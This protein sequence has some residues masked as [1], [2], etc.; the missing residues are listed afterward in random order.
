MPDQFRR[1]TWVKVRNGDVTEGISL[2]RSGSAGSRAAAAVWAPYHMAL[3]AAA[4]ETAGQIDEGLALFDDALQIVERTGERS[5]GGGATPTQRP[6][7]AAAG[8]VRGRQG[9]L[10]ESPEHRPRAG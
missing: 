6:T 9:T 1:S 8:A 3:V 4:Y 2:L 10:S 7:V 5:I